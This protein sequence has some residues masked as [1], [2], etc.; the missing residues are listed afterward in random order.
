[1]VSAGKK[2][3]TKSVYKRLKKSMACHH[4][5][6]PY[7]TN[8]KNLRYLKNS[9]IYRTSDGWESPSQLDSPLPCSNTIQLT[10]KIH[11]F[12]SVN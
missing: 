11:R 10:P 1:M 8:S 3:N 12:G 5:D 2:G 4:D 7:K 6:T 9:E